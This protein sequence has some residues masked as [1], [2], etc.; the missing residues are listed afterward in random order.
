M[1]RAMVLAMVLAMGAGELNPAGLGGLSGARI[2]PGYWP[3]AGL[4]GGLV[5]AFGGIV[6]EV[7]D[8]P[9]GRSP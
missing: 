2:G 5:E 7:L 4:A 1:G 8:A 9:F 3:G 6:A